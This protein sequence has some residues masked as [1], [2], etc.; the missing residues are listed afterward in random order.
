MILN[1]IFAVSHE[2]SLLLVA[3]FDISNK[4]IR[5]S[6]HSIKSLLLELKK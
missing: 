6:Q 2:N 5:L 4:H 1:K 3:P